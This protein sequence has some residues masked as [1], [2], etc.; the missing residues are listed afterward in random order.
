MKNTLFMFIVTFLTMSYKSQA[1][2]LVDSCEVQMFEVIEYNLDTFETVSRH[3]LFYDKIN[4]EFIDENGDYWILKKKENFS[5]NYKK[6]LI[7]C[8]IAF[9]GGISSGYHETTLNHYPKFKAVHPYANNKYFNPAESWVNKYKNGDPM[10]GEAF[11]LSTTAL[12][13]FTDFYHLTNT[14][15]RLGL[16]GSTVYVT[17]GEKRKW[18]EYGIDIV[19]TYLFRLVGFHLIYSGIYK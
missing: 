13:P 16:L 3:N 8:S 10:Q 15:D 2:T 14:I 4:K 19:A 11:F 17:I 5:W 1:Q 12:V 7:G 18:W 9:I 6:T